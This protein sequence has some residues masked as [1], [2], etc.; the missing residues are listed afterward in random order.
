[1]SFN[2]LNSITYNAFKLVSPDTTEIIWLIVNREEAGDNE[3]A[4]SLLAK[5]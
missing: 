4:I 3:K 2:K 5:N 1:V